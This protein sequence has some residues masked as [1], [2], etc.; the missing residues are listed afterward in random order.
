MSLWLFIWRLNPPHNWHFQTI[1]KSLKNDDNTL[2][3]LWSPRKNDEKNP[4]SFEKRKY[5]LEKY[6]KNKKNLK[7]LE[8]KD[9]PSDLSWSL[10]IYKLICD[11]FPREK[12][13]NFYGWD[14]EN[15]SA[16]KVI[17][18]Y[19]KFFFKY[20][21]NFIE[22][23]R[24]NSFVEHNSEKI[25]ISATNLRKALKDKDNNLTNKLTKKEVLNEL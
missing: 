13:I 25:E 14:F 22:N 19:K 17:N 3:L 7:I 20:S 24:K 18:H 2:V 11:N 6:F 21:L 15:D 10:E 9:I 23:S 12:I 5:I 16:Y 1:E 8:I 4:Y